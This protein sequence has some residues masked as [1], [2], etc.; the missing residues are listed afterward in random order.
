MSNMSPSRQ[1][2]VRLARKIPGLRSAWYLVL[3]LYEFVRRR[4]SDARHELEALFQAQ[5]DPWDYASSPKEQRRLQRELQT[6]A[7]LCGP[8]RIPRAL[9]IGCAEGHFTTMLADR[10]ES[11][12]CFDFSPTALARAQQRRHWPDSVRFAHFDLYQDSIPG[13]FDLIVIIC[14]IDYIENP[15]ATMKIRAALVE[16][17]APGGILLVGNSLCNDVMDKAWWGRVLIRGGYS[18]ARYFAGHPRLELL[19]EC[20]LDDHLDS[21]FRKR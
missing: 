8:A 13:T 16:A 12:T 9:E 21:V 5:P 14:V 3:E 17:L 1:R 2:L 15:L 19:Q 7:A 6:I 10:C 20:E 11:L 18:I 4:R